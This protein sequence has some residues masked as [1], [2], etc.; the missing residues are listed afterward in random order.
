MLLES[1]ENSR[2]FN[3]GHLLTAQYISECQG[4]VNDTELLN[5]VLVFWLGKD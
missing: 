4:S 3:I 5:V 1:L 2:P